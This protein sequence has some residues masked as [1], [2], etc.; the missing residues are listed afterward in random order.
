[1][2]ISRNEGYRRGAGKEGPALDAAQAFLFHLAGIETERITDPAE[3]YR[4]GDLRC[5]NRSTVEVKGQPIDPAK[6]PQNFV[7]V[8][9]DTTAARR[10]HHA[11][12]FETVA[13]S[14]GVSATVLAGLPVVRFDQPGRPVQPLGRVAF[15]STSVQSIAG[16]AA[17]IYCNVQAGHL[18][19]YRSQKLLE[20]VRE[21]ALGEGF[22]RGQGKSN[23]DTY[24]VLASVAVLRWLRS[25]EGWEFTGQPDLRDAAAD[26]V[27]R[28]LGM[29]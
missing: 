27:R 23:R 14:L 6:Y 8:F 20:F 9:E 25:S 5:P 7:E 24:A 22:R 13:R 2:P 18:Y 3:N 10:E 12:G 21:A 26:Q 29:T 4:F 19:F 16:S 17:T 28:T 11:D 1:M 15:V